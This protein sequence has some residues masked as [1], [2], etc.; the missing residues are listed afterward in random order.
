MKNKKKKRMTAGGAQWKDVRDLYDKVHKTL[1][2]PENEKMEV[3]VKDIGSYQIKVP[4]DEGQT[5]GDLK[6]MIY[7]LSKGDTI[8]WDCWCK[9]KMRIMVPGGGEGKDDELLKNGELYH[10]A[11]K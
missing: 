11:P 2:T 6:N 9:D 4:F 8:Q 7:E 1:P 5:I 10:I 3:R